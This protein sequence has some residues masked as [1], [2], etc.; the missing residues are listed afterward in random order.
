MSAARP[1]P[2]TQYLPEAPEDLPTSFLTD[3]D[4]LTVFSLDEDP[5]G[6]AVITIHG[7]TGRDGVHTKDLYQEFVHPVSIHIAKLRSFLLN[8]PALK[9]NYEMDLISFMLWCVDTGRCIDGS[10][11]FI[12]KDVDCFWDYCSNANSESP[13]YHPIYIE[14]M[15]DILGDDMPQG[16]YITPR[17]QRPGCNT[18]GAIPCDACLFYDHAARI[19]TRQR[20]FNVL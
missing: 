6:K 17:F 9:K 1:Y 3:L 18:I 19:C 10:T 15:L 20:R 16:M 7:F 12:E 8:F 5:Q 13:Y 14:R 11:C 4:D 2:F